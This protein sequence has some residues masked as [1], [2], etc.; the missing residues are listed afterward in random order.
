[1]SFP[2]GGGDLIS[3]KKMNKYYIACNIGRI[4]LP[5]SV[6]DISDFYATLELLLY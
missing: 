4:Y 5:T 6:D 3:I 2:D 1:M